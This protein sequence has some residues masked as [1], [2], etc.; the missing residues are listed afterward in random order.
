[1]RAAYGD[2]PAYMISGGGGGGYGGSG[3]GAG[4]QNMFTD[5]GAM[6]RPVTYTP[7]ARVTTGYYGQAIQQTSFTRGLTGTL[8]LNDVPRGTFAYDYGLRTATDFGE[9]VG[10]GIAAGA[11][12]GAGLAFGATAG[13]AIGGV[14]GGIAGAAFGPVGSAAGAMMGKAFGGYAMGMAGADYTNNALAQRRG[15]EAFVEATSSRYIG[16]GSEMA[17]PR[18][19]AGMSRGNRQKVSEFIRTQDIKDPTMDTGDLTK[20]LEEGTRLGMM[21]GTQNIEG[22]KKKFKDLVDGVKVVSKVFQTTIEESMKVMKDF[23]GIGVDAS[24]VRDLSLQSDAVGRAT[25]RTA[26]EVMGLGMQGAELFR[27][28]GVEMS[29]GYQANV[30]NLSSVR[31]ARDAGKLSN[32]AIAQAGGEEALSA[33]MTASGLQ[34]AQSNLGRGFAA[35][36]YGKQGF[37]QDAF[38]Q[39]TQGGE[40]DYNKLA[41]QAVKNLGTPGAVIGFQ[42]NQEKI[43]SKMGKEFGGQGLQ[44]GQNVEAMS[45]ASFMVQSGVTKNMEEALRYSFIEIGLGHPEIETRL[46]SMKNAQGEF[47]ARQAGAE[48]TRVRNMTEEAQSNFLFYRGKQKVT[49]AVNSVVDQV[50]APLSNFVGRTSEA[51]EDF[52]HKQTEGITRADVR[53]IDYAGYAGTVPLDPGAA[54]GPKK[55]I[56]LDVGGAFMGQ[57]VGEKVAKNIF[58]GKLAPFGLSKTRDITR[59]E[60]TRPDEVE[61]WT[62]SGG[63]RRAVK[64]A[65]LDKAVEASRVSTM[66]VGEAQRMK[67]EGLLKDTNPGLVKALRENTVTNESSVDEISKAT[68]GKPLAELDRK[69]YATLLLQAQTFPKIAKKLDELREGAMSLQAV[70]DRISVQELSE[71]KEEIEGARKSASGKLGVDLSGEAFQLLSMA[72]AK[73]NRDPKEASR[74]LDKAVEVQSED[75]NR[76]GV[77]NNTTLDEITTATKRFMEEDTFKV[78]AGVVQRAA[79][80]I[81]KVQARRGTSLLASSVEL[82]LQKSTLTGTEQDSVRE[83]VGKLGSG[84]ALDLQGISKADVELLNK[85]STGRAITQQKAVVDKIQELSAGAAGTQESKI[86]GVA[87][88]G[89]DPEKRAALFKEGMKGIAGVSEEQI[90]KLTDTFVSRGG[91]AAA[92]QAV[93]DFTGQ[94]AGGTVTSG[95]GGT[96]LEA[97]KGTAEENLVLQTNI[98][99]QILSALSALNSRL[100]AR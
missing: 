50:V 19:G 64:R 83:A 37:D 75:A 92:D 63:F 44:M 100:G 90:A 76:Q 86:L 39:V 51:A 71:S 3:A 31:A 70:G 24:R 89:N 10:G 47:S 34:F 1:M 17:D 96:P 60:E 93:A 58:S 57:S 16:A 13:S 98:N 68:Y 5:V 54:R 95:P 79:A 32:E 72:R 18:T 91:E 46:A 69:E 61:V 14:L 82:D 59:E 20:I 88:K 99:L 29:I 49:D 48:A 65:D 74:L 55:A 62:T 85:T 8:G 56:D 40:F 7:P 6:I 38:R 11:V 45:R 94:V 30:M 42:A 80:D 9:R 12:T 67:E 15:I 22:F 52:Y 2:V 97:G 21:V 33:R 78:D 66:S 73:Q 77:F 84:K 35:T 28:T 41:L 81:T 27:G 87:W 36:F 43:L 4:L 26:Q 53:G 25:G 23:K